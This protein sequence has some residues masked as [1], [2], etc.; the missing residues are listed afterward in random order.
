[1]TKAE[2]VRQAMGEFAA[3]R[4][5][6]ATMLA[7]VKTVKEAEGLCDVEDGDGLAYYDVRLMPLMVGQSACTMV[8]AVG[9]S[10]LM[11]RID[12]GDDWWLLW[13]SVATRYLLMAGPTKITVDADGL[14]VKKGID[15]LGGLIDDLI[16]EIQAI[17]AP[18]NVAAITA[19]QV[20]FRA[21]LNNQ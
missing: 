9:S 8:P 3:K 18:K 11:C 4:G 15:S 10:C 6:S 13:C 17:Y 14:L 2:Q 5:P 7:T 19:L 1:M 21:L 20:R 16:T 12:G